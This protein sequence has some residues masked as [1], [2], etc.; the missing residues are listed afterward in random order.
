MEVVRLMLVTQIAELPEGGR[1][2]LWRHRP[3]LMVR[4]P[5]GADVGAL[6]WLAVP[7]AIAL[8][9]LGGGIAGVIC[10]DQLPLLT[11]VPTARVSNRHEILTDHVFSGLDVA[12]GRQGMKYDAI[13][14][15]SFTISNTPQ[16]PQMRSFSI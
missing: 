6:G 14:L 16:V 4:R 7:L 3:E 8:A 13:P 11:P 2:E 10:L 9:N 1:W 5:H 15:N 12:T